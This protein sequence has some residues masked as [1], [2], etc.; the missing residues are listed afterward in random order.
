MFLKGRISLKGYLMPVSQIKLHCFTKLKSK[1]LVTG[2]F[3]GFG[4]PPWL[5]GTY[6]I[7][8]V[9][10]PPRFLTETLSWIFKGCMHSQNGF[11]EFTHPWKIICKM[12][13]WNTNYVYNYIIAS[14]F[15]NSQT[16]L[17]AI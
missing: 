15:G 11:W 10:L 7:L 1:T 16:N 12:D 17:L 4:M 9:H 13:L 8:E 5:L 3:I 6:Q 14:C 2:L